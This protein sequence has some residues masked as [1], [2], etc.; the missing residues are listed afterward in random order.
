MLFSIVN[1]LP[2]LISNGKA[3]PVSINDGSV[4]VDSGNAKP[5]KE[6]GTYTLDEI[7]RKLGKN[8]S[9]IPE[10]KRVKKEKKEDVR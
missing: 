7:T 8:V 4:S 10:K 9:S 6:T 5:T 3:I 2:Y 1:G